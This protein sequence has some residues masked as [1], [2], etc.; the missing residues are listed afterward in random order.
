MGRIVIYVHSLGGGA[1]K[2]AILYANIL[3]NHGFEVLLVTAADSN[4]GAAKKLNANVKHLA[5]DARRGIR[6]VFLLGRAVRHF[7]PIKALVIGP[8]NLSI[9]VAAA[10]SFSFKG[11]LIFRQSN[12]VSATLKYY[13]KPIASVK[14]RLFAVSLRRVSRIIALTQ[15][16]KEELVRD[17]GFPEQQVEIIPNGVVTGR[18]TERRSMNVVPTFLTPARLHRQKDH[19]TLLRAFAIV[20]KKVECRIVLAGDGPERERL[21][22]LVKE[23]GVS[24]DVVFSGF[25]EDLDELYRAADVVVLASRHEGFPNVLIEAISFA[26]PVVSTDC[27][28][29]PR[30][31]IAGDEIGLLAEVGNPCSLACAMERALSKTFRSEIL[32]ERARMFS[33]EK[34]KERVVDFFGH[35]FS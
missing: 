8:S 9:F 2:N 26:R 24:R 27:P 30:E 19:E 16:L 14:S 18:E 34:V 20:R 31:I 6:L 12:S 28:T 32:L 13:P 3:N 1:G 7:S 33:E 22:E 11:E 17:W 10:V 25:V 21:G 35:S 15:G 5:I 29:G 4:N 23:L